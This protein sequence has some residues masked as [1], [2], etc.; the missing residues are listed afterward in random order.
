MTCQLVCIPPDKVSVLWPVISPLIEKA[1]VRGN[2]SR[3]EP[4]AKD[5]LEGGSLL[6]VASEVDGG[7]R[8]AAVT[9]MIETEL[10]K[11][12]LIVACGGTDRGRW[13]HLLQPIERWAKSEG[14][15]AMRIMGRK[16]WGSVLRD[17]RVTRVVLDRV[18]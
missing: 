4:I 13:L 16:G 7:I 1:I 15:F 18:L 9:R 12:C 11:Y 8:A 5:V 14:C 6:W 2:L 10:H 17:Y 3:F